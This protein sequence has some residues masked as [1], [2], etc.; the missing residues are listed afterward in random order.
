MTGV[1]LLVLSGAGAF[2]WFYWLAPLRHLSS[3]AWMQD[4]TPKQIWL[5]LQR[6]LKHRAGYCHWSGSFLELW[7]N[8]ESA[9]WLIG[10]FKAGRTHPDCGDGHLDTALPFITNQEL[11]NET[12]NWI[13]WWNT[14][15]QKTQE[16]W[17]RDGF[18]K[19]G[20]EVTRQLTTNNV[21]TLLKILDRNAT[22][23]V[24]ATGTNKITPSLRYNAFRWLR[25]AGVGPRSVD[26][27]SLPDAEKNSLIRGLIAYAEDWGTYANHPG[28]IFKSVDDGSFGTP[29]ILKDCFQ[30]GL[31]MLL[32]LLAFG[33][34]RIL[35]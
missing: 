7:G 10:E 6:E 25:D 11:G 30:W 35:R 19:L 31:T 4:H 23:I 32:A 22:N 29:W 20:I 17:I 8:K 21:I 33:G 2:V 28:R 24:T 14:N 13:A 27:P 9:D 26:F 3:G 15:G 5:E 34:W 1:F 16:E 18:S 12:N